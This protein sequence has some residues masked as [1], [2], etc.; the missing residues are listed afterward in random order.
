MSVAP[1]ARLPSNLL[2]ASYE[3]ELLV[4]VRHGLNHFLFSYVLNRNSCLAF[5]RYV[6]F[7]ATPPIGQ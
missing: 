2:V 1:A 5:Q 3:N 7:D 4:R 6:V